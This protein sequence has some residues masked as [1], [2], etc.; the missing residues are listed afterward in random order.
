MM[1]LFR[2]HHSENHT[3]VFTAAAPLFSSYA[4]VQL[5]KLSVRKSCQHVFFQDSSMS[6]LLQFTNCLEK[7]SLCAT[8]G[9]D[10]ILSC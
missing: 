1:E 5:M 8:G 2:P 7:I 9:Y 10:K 6:E 3:D 4:G